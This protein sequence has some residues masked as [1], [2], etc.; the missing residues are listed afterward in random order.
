MAE[1]NITVPK[2]LTKREVA[3][4]FNCSLPT[5]NNM[6]RIGKLKYHKFGNLVRFRADELPILN[7]EIEA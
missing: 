7:R 4:L 1:H 3:K 6:M 2:I 5:I